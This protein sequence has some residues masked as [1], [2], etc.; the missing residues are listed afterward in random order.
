MAASETPSPRRNVPR[1][2][3]GLVVDTLGRRIVSGA[4]PE[5]A[6][7]PRDELLEEEL[8]VSRTVIREAMKTLAAKGLIVARTRVGT[9]VCVRERWNLFDSDVL[10]W[11]LEE[12]NQA[13]FLRQI[14]EMRLAFEP[15]AAALAAARAT[16]DE[17]AQ[18]R[19]QISEM[20][21]VRDRNEFAT[22]DLDFHRIILAAARNSI[23]LSVANVIELALY[24][25]MH[26]GSPVENADR[27]GMIADMHNDIV[28]AIA[29]GDSDRAS[30]CMQAVI[31]A[32]QFRVSE[33]M[34]D[35]RVTTPP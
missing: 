10:T 9:S 33:A 12:G 2:S 11:H 13:D 32:G 20:R 24:V 6:L 30:R 8:S 16:P 31:T 22:V 19:T 29:A 26:K 14:T 1:S 7:L 3:H 27:Q 15:F 34:P 28:E 17:V 35:L 5:G 23:L 21:R 18:L 25:V 4:L